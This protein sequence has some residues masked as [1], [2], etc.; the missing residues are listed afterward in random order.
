VR[1]QG[2]VERAER[3]PAP[4]PIPQMALRVDAMRGTIDGIRHPL[5]GGMEEFRAGPAGHR[6]AEK[7]RLRRLLWHPAS[8]RGVAR[9]G[10]I[11]SGGLFRARAQKC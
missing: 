10:R 3:H 7:E 11:P 1:K 8:P 5:D 4:H 6:K 2:V 9:H